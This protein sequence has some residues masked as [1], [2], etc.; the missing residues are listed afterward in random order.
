MDCPVYNNTHQSSS[1]DSIPVSSAVN[2]TFIF[3]NTKEEHR[4]FLLYEQCRNSCEKYK[5]GGDATCIFH[6][7]VTVAGT[8]MIMDIRTA[9][10]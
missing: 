7:P 5:T 6:F 3:K 2:S 4:L 10:S 1:G 9:K 8:A